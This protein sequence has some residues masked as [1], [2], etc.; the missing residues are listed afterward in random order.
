MAGY[1]T[2][3]LSTLFA[4]ALGARVFTHW[5]KSEWGKLVT[6][7]LGA[8]IAGYCIYYPQ[9]AIDI[10]TALGTLL[11]NLFKPSGG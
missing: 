9:A 11:A 2:S 8:A 6:C 4:I 10:L 5:G 1:V 3:I 7:L